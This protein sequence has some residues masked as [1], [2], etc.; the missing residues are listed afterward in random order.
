MV[1]D[2]TLVLALAVAALVLLTTATAT[3]VA[4]IGWTAVAVFAATVAA[5][6]RWRLG[7]RR[8]P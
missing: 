3:G 1:A 7:R 6:A 4:V 5:Y 2:R 8:S